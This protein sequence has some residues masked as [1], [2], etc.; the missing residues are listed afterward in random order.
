MKKHALTVVNDELVSATEV[1]TQLIKLQQLLCGFIV[2]NDGKTIE[3]KNNRINCML[4]AIEEMSGKVIIW[5]RFR[6]DI[7]AITNALKKNMV[8]Y[9]L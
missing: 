9:L 6:H 3:V 7:V 8:M 4:D 1:M 2:T 5:A